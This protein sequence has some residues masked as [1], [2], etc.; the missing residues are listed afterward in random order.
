[1]TDLRVKFGIKNT[2]KA[3]FFHSSG[4]AK[5]QSGEN[6]GSTA[7]PTFR[8]TPGTTPA[9]TT[10]S[11]SNPD[12]NTPVT[13]VTPSSTATA[14]ADQA[15]NS[16]PRYVQQYRHSKIMQGLHPYNHLKSNVPQVDR[17]A[18]TAR[19]RGTLGSY[20]PSQ[21]SSDLSSTPSTGTAMSARAASPTGPT[22]P[23]LG[24][25]TTAPPPHR[26][27][28]ISFGNH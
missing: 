19:G 17:V 27:S 6:I 13:P 11:V 4:Y 28:P 2:E 16:Q 15:L 22:A 7:S 18:N 9:N 24:S 20:E 10:F 8:A 23:P 1:M 25:A 12:A 3:D 26:T 14:A 5:A 21:R